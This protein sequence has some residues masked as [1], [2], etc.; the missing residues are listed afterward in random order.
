MARKNVNLRLGDLVASEKGYEQE[1][2]AVPETEKVRTSRVSDEDSV[3]R[4]RL[5]ANE[6][7]DLSEDT[8]PDPKNRGASPDKVPFRTMATADKLAKLGRK[9]DAI[10]LLQTLLRAPEL[11]TRIELLVWTALRG[12]GVHPGPRAEREV[13]GVIMEVPLPFIRGCVAM[14][15][16]GGAKDCSW[17]GVDTIAAYADGSL[18][19]LGGM[20][21]VVLVDYNV[22]AKL[23]QLC[24]DLIESTES[25]VEHAT[26]RTDLSLPMVP[27]VTM[28]TR[29]GCFVYPKPPC[30]VG[31]A[32]VRLQEWVLR[33]GHVTTPKPP[34]T[35]PSQLSLGPSPDA[36]EQEQDDQPSSSESA[37]TF[38]CK[39]C[40]KLLTRAAY[41]KKVGKLCKG[42]ASFEPTCIACK[43]M[44]RDA[45]NA[46]A[47]ARFQ[48]RIEPL[49]KTGFRRSLI[50]FTA[51][52]LGDDFTTETLHAAIL[53]R[54]K[55]EEDCGICCLPYSKD[56]IMCLRPCCKQAICIQCDRA[57]HTERQPCA[58]CRGVPPTEIET[59]AEKAKPSQYRHRRA[60]H[61]RKR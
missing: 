20:G 33:G 47:V 31:F 36:L 9:D 50:E 42:D 1:E 16:D 8:E 44:C 54:Y 29:A 52:S 34:K 59:A 28:C 14:S 7:W 41:S 3:L 39:V 32:S 11:E 27:Q 2:L 15:A 55:E 25:V 60:T 17:E 23:N 35:I 4:K 53:E 13:L 22:D 21:H 5:F 38:K 57:C 19:Y 56:V 30:E 48:G 18:K 49:L 6:P 46:A 43:E 12:L 45:E 51:K 24:H 58:F 37:A 61:R 10:R 40:R 26:L